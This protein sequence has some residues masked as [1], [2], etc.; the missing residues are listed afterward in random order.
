MN[1]PDNISQNDWFLLCKTHKNIG[2]IIKK[3]E[4]GY[5]VQYLIGYVDFYGI[6]I[7]VNK[8]TLIPRYETEYLVEKTINYIKNNF[9]DS[10]NIVDAGTGSG[11]IAIKLKNV[12][13]NKKELYYN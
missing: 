1:K 8:H 10:V 3:L 11:C 2:S 13:P 12:F 7:N 5:P 6:K 9:N 4:N